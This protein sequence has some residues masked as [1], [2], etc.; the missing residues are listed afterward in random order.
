[1]GDVDIERVRAAFERWSIS[2]DEV[3]NS[4]RELMAPDCVV[5]QSGLPTVNSTEEAIAI[6]EGARESIGMESMKVDIVHMVAADGVILGERIDHLLR[7]DGSLII[8]I[9]VA[10]VMEFRD[11]RI[12]HW[13]EYFDPIPMLKLVSDEKPS[14]WQTE[15]S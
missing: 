2:I 4:M 1:M 3:V 10:G 14:S 15:D 9:P 7:K 11:G 13:R 6:I 8:S 12:V 5:E